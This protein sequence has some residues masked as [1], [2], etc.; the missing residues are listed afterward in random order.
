MATEEGAD[1]KRD[2]WVGERKETRLEKM[3]PWLGHNWTT[4]CFQRK[5]DIWPWEGVMMLSKE[6]DSAILIISKSC[7]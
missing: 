1:A 6:E 4:K 5:G 7:L 2:R 3:A